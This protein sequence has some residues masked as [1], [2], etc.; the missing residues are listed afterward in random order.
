MKRLT[1]LLALL[2]SLLALLLA[3]LALG[4]AVFVHRLQKFS[5][6]CISL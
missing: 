4:L 3:L 6:I 1:L 5:G 2:L